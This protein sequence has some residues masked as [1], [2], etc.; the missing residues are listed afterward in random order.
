ME[1]PNR[2]DVTKKN[3]SFLSQSYSISVGLLCGSLMAVAFRCIFV[4]IHD[5]DVRIKNIAMT[6]Q[7]TNVFEIHY[8]P[9]VCEFEQIGIQII[10]MRFDDCIEN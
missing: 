7:V 6:K 10:T 1:F 8:G 4:S 2:K 5:S 3:V 9:S